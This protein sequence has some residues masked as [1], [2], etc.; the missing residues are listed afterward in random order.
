MESRNLRRHRRVHAAGEDPSVIAVTGQRV[1][2]TNV[3]VTLRRLKVAAQEEMPSLAAWM[4]AHERATL[5]G[6]DEN[7]R[8]HR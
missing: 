7:H 8:H 4:A 2:R 6:D 5:D 1:T 3:R